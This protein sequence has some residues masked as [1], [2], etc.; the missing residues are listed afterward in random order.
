MAIY[1]L[2][3]PAF[4]R[5]QSMP[6]KTIYLLCSTSTSYHADVCKEDRCGSGTISVPAV[7][8]AGYKM[9]DGAAL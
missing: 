1:H 7:E 6:E 2:V 3:T 9:M 5:G 4:S 8:T